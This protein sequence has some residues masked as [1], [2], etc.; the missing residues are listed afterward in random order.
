V[1]VNALPVS[2]VSV[3]E[4]SGVTA[5]DGTICFG[6]SAVLTASGG[7]QYAWST[8]QNN[9]V[10]TVSP[11]NNTAYTVTV[12]DANMCSSSTTRSISVGSPVTVGISL[13]ETSGIANNDGSICAGSSAT[14]SLSGASSYLWPDGSTLAS[15]QLTP[16]CTKTYNLTVTDGS[17][18][19]TTS[20]VTVL[21]NSQPEVA[22]ITP[23]SGTAGTVIHIYGQGLSNTIEVRF[24]GQPG[25]S[26]N[27][28][29]DTHV[30]ALMPVSGS[31]QQLEV[32][33]ACGTTTVLAVSPVISSISPASGSV[34]TVVTVSGLNLDQIN[35][36]AIGGTT[37]VILSR[38]STTARLLVMP[39]TPGGIVDVSTP[40]STASSSSAFTVSNT[41]HPYIQQGAKFTNNST[42]S[43]QGQSVAV[44]ADGN[45]AI[46]GG[47]GDNSNTGAAWIYVRTGTAW[48]QQAKLVGSGAVGAA[49]QG[50]SVAVS[51]DGNTAVI[52]GSADNSN[53]GAAWVF[54]RTGTDW[55]QQGSKL[56]GAGGTG[57]SQQG[58]A[59]AISAD[60]NK[61]ASGGI[62][63]NLFD[64]AVW[65]FE[66]NGNSWTQSG[67]KLTPAGGIEKPRLGVSV[68]L[69]ADG[70]RLLAGGYLDNI[71]QGAAWVF[72]ESGCGMTQSGQKLVG[73]GGNTSA[74][75]GYSVS[76][77]ADGKTA[78]IGGCNDN[79]L[80]G[81]AWIFTNDSGSNWTQQVRL[82]GG[83]ATGS[84]RQGSAVALSADGNTAI[85][86]G[87]T[88]DSG[89][90][91]AWV[92]KKTVGGTWVQQDAK[93]RG[94][95][96]T[97]AS[98]QG[99]SVAVSANGHT[100]L[101]GGPVDATNTGAFWV[102][103]PGTLLQSG[104]SGDRQASG[105]DA[106]S[107]EFSLEQNIPNPTAGLTV[108]P[109]NLPESCVAEWE[110]TDVSGRVIQFIR[111]EYPAGANIES[112]D[113]S[114]YSGMY[115]YRL[116]TP[117]GCL[118]KSMLIVR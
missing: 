77:S 26:L 110:I 114:R 67:E 22:Q 18:C 14:V 70:S 115:C 103:I 94:S 39:G 21:V 80:V 43:Q 23:S 16:A 82:V 47:P 66:R 53:N 45:T 60:G 78:M 54:T 44:S 57:A 24:N 64:G 59:V 87:F 27:I 51:S 117:F 28:I 95:N 85:S 61:I 37:A 86:C 76:L 55:T 41:P 40:T 99:T 4:N 7:T 88:D 112:F 97:G 109:F 52:G 29:S 13:Q 50:I 96:A 106:A 81:S 65:V 116:K 11:V 19:V 3:T 118:S 111:R 34:G 104:D 89:K 68:A 73:T 8:T 83:G 30:T 72:D 15:R 58:S 108:V 1:T 9:A 25:T 62:A 79:N 69:S 38:S 35:S 63:D 17:S 2:A 105:E 92:Y 48:S 12:T 93:F 90:G 102:F 36:A 20:S 71:R 5:N 6:T 91:A 49:R 32:L 10:I 107:G 31:V 100:A 75:Q 33:S 42:S 84:A 113:M 74:W 101:I 56:V 98:R 46:I